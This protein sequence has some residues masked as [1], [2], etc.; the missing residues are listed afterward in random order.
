MAIG[1]IT[2]LRTTRI[3]SVLTAI[4][5]SGFV[6]I[7]DGTKPATVGGTA[8]TRLAHIPLQATAGT[9]ASGVL[10]FNTPMTVA[11][12]ASG[13]AT[14]ARLT[15]SAGSAVADMT[16]GTGAADLNFDSVSFVAAGTVT[17]TAL[18]ITEG[19]L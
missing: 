15:T 2:T 16:V 11:A 10:T 8:T 18:S 9:V 13:T 17:I 14:W 12:A 19:N 3:T 7:Y 1:Y 5:A 4:G 6:D